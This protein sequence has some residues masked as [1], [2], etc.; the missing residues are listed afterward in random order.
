MRHSKQNF[1]MKTICLDY[2][3]LEENRYEN[4]EH[5]IVDADSNWKAAEHF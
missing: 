3:S 4:S 5:L 1:V 2:L